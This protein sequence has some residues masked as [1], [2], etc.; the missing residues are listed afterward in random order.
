MW[1][2]LWPWI[3][4]ET[5]VVSM[6]LTSRRSSRPWRILHPSKC[7][8]QPLCKLFIGKTVAAAYIHVHIRTFMHTH[9]YMGMYIW[10][11]AWEADRRALLN[12][13]DAWA[14][15]AWRSTAAWQ[16]FTLLWISCGCRAHGES[17]TCIPHGMRTKEPRHIIIIG[18]CKNAYI[19]TK[20]MS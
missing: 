18:G 2:W 11:V 19:C 7:D 10:A 13:M 6:R 12:C 9:T 8:V 20:H 17:S 14:L 1:S 16:D 5:I 15:W 4:T 3:L